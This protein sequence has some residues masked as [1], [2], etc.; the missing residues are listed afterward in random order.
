MKKVVMVFEEIPEMTSNERI[1][2]MV[3]SFSALISNSDGLRISVKNAVK[4][5]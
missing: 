3:G 2:I 4:E 5:I 1:D